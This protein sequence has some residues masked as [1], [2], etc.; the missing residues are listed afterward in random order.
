M[1]E[2]VPITKLYESEC[3]KLV[4]KNK[5]DPSSEL[6]PI[7]IKKLLINENQESS[8]IYGSN[9]RIKI[10]SHYKSDHC[11]YQ[12]IKKFNNANNELKE[13]G[14]LWS[15]KRM[16]KEEFLQSLPKCE[17]NN[18]NICMLDNRRNY[19]RYMLY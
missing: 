19:E 5:L 12:I 6:Q 2:I 4:F 18:C 8:R 1:A 14:N 13:C 10:P 11:M 9:N 15:L 3:I 17:I 7:A 16:L